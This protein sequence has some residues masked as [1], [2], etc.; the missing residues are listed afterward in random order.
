MAYNQLYI[1][2]STTLLEKRKLLGIVVTYF[3][4]NVLVQPPVFTGSACGY[5]CLECILMLI[6]I[7]DFSILY[8][9]SNH[10]CIEF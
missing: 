9:V 10:N 7:V 6:H 1:F 5:I 4:S 2:G 3:P 8:T